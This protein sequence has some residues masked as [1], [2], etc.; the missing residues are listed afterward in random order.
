MTPMTAGSLLR[1][2]RQ[3]R[4]LSQEGLAIRAGVASVVV[5]D[6]E[7][8]RVS[9]TVETLGAL[10]ELLGE[11]LVL[12]VKER[13]SGID[14]TLNRGNLVL[15]PEHRVEKGLAF[16]DAVREIRSGGAEELGRSVQLSPLLGALERHGVDFVVVGSIAGL[17]HGSAYPTY[18]VDVAYAGHSD[19]LNQMAMALGELGL[20]IDGHRLGEHNLFSFDTEY[21]TLD[22]LR[23]I[24][25]VE[26]YGQLRRDSTREVLAGILVQVASLN[27][28]ISMKR[29][30]NRTKD[31]LMVLEYV[32]LAE[33]LR[34]RGG[35][36]ADA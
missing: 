15:R 32:E 20:Q 31:Q 18:D 8:D 21:G 9:P 33:E 34:R 11:D 29:A 4:G 35:E 28:L 30:A 27:H 26:T 5:S 22:I 7:A 19:N 23:R 1:K 25:G 12:G 13:K 24:P 17:A 6:F 14:I 36:D 16:A 3:G 10:L 2:T